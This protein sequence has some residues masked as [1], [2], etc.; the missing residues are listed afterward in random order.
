MPRTLHDIP[1]EILERILALVLVQS[2]EP[3]SRPAWHAYPSKSAS[4]HPSSAHAAT[5]SPLLVCRAWLR[6]ATPIHYRHP[7]LRTPRHVELLLR[8]VRHSPALARCIRSLHVHA[9]S[10]ALR[11][12]VPYCKNLDTLD[13]TVDNADAD[14]IT[15]TTTVVPPRDGSRDRGVMEFCEAFSRTR[16]IRHLVIRKNAYLTQ[17]NAIYVFEQLSLAIALWHK[18]V[19]L[20]LHVSILSISAPALLRARKRFSRERAP[21][22]RHGDGALC[23]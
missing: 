10:P 4:S 3:S 19:S 17:S 5:I 23:A 13:I 11:D 22:S 14:A 18:L 16:S 15:V 20:S 21:A 12:L 1:E 2:P 9:T 6:I 7:V 8:A